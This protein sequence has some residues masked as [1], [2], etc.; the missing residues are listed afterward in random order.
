MKS[1]TRLVLGS[2]LVAAVIGGVALPF[3]ALRFLPQCAN[4]R[5]LSYVRQRTEFGH[6]HR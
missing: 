3:R 4:L 2:A 1:K 6:G 5:T